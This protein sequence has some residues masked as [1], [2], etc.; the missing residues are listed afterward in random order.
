M[1]KKITKIN[2]ELY[3]GKTS[4]S[5]I[6]R[7]EFTNKELRENKDIKKAVKFYLKNFIHLDNSR[8]NALMRIFRFEHETADIIINIELKYKNNEE[9]D[10]S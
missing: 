3:R 5:S 1:K 7:K 9:K 4:I 10:N 6:G 2:D 8:D